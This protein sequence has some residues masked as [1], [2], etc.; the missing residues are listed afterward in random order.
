MIDE[1]WLMAYFVLNC[2]IF[3][4]FL[5]LVKLQSSELMETI[6]SSW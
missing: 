4:F 6:V 2:A 5:R 3:F 1:D